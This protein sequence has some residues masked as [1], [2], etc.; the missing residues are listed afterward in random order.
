MEQGQIREPFYTFGLRPTPYGKRDRG[1]ISLPLSALSYLKKLKGDR[2][3][4]IIVQRCN[5]PQP[6][7]CHYSREICKFLL[8]LTLQGIVTA[9]LERSTSRLHSTYCLSNIF[10]NVNTRLKS[11]LFPMDVQR[12]L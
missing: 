2:S 6:Q 5:L 8:T 11:G 4:I 1:H 12:L 3:F 10:S 7:P 9:D